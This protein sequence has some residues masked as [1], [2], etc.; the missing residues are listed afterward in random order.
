[1]RRLLR[2]LLIPLALVFLFEAWL[3]GHL[4]P[5]VAWIVARVPL[6]R[7]KAQIAVRIEALPPAATFGVF[8]LPV[9]LLLPFKFLALWALARGH[10]LTAV[11]LLALAKVVSVGVTAFIFEVTRPKLLQLS[12]FRRLYHGVLRWLAA[13]PSLLQPISPPLQDSFRMF[14]P[15]RAG[16]TLKLLARIRQRAQARAA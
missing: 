12:W 8:V 4:A 16:R 6:D 11:G 15:R 1:M 9:L 2:F 5:I 7:F 3:W 13:A 10:W 14:S